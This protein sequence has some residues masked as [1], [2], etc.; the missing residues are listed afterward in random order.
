MAPS[1]AT[2]TPL[3][4]IGVSPGLVAG[5]VARMAPGITEPEIATLDP[6]RDIDKECDRIA[7]AAQT[8]K[9]GLELSAAEAK[10]D[11]RTLLETTAQMAADPTLTSS[12]Q[13]MVRE[14]RL[15]PE[16]AVWEAAG[17]L[18][19]MLESLGGYMAERTRDVQDVRDRIVAVL[20]DSP[21]PGI[22][23]LPEP[24]VLVAED[25]APADTALLDPE[26]VVAFVTSE[27][28]P[29]SHTAILARALGMPAIVGTGAEVTDQL[30]DGDIVLVD[31][32]KGTIVLDPSE[33]QLRR[34]RELA[35]RVR[36]FNGDGATKD[37]HEVQL[38]ANVGDGA[39]ARSAA[40]ANAMGVGLFRT[41]FCFLDQPEEPSV[42]EQV[43]A[44]KAVL[45]AFPGKKVVVRT[46]DAGA[47]KP[48][49]FLTDATEANPA[50]G[51][52]A[53]RTT[54]RDP[55]VL[56]HQL[57]ALAKAEA[58]TEAKVWVMAP[59]ISTAEEAKA[60]TE[61][62]RSYGLQ[63][64]GMMIEVPS[65]AIM[66]DKMFEHADFASI[67]TNDLTQYVMAA[68]R[69]L[70]SLADLSTA[71]QPAVLRLI[72]QA[73]DGAA[74]HGRPV[75]VCGEAAADPALATV[76]VGLGVAS[77]SM[78][79]RALPDVDAVLKSVDLADCQRLAGIATASATADEARQAVRA[80]LPILEE[81]GL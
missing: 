29:T 71:W 4:G 26:K 11:G 5:P 37:G 22:P 15:V 39:A 56:D 1:A 79:A 32:T 67:G 30:S 73:C 45:A 53:Y 38:L 70:S 6:S 31:G 28:G 42:D 14:R 40:E 78:T 48:L 51:V 35:S 63:T 19:S 64:A 36:V 76:L 55:E 3:T 47:D 33:D 52:R 27:G 20:T 12:A 13:A 23:R 57:E 10:G 43:E 41:E 68:D 49:P 9:K 54:R 8:V 18:A 74:P 21:M 80:E 46:L 61:K 25:L 58:E 75:G 62:A 59:M 60:F 7:A 50:L 16:R 72:K 2:P 65:A 34:A 66:A 24:F 44:Y 81:L 77:L 69:L 17:T